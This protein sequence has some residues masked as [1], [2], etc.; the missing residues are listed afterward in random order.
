M[1]LLYQ[2]GDIP[3]YGS[4][5]ASDGDVSLG[6]DRSWEIKDTPFTGTG[7]TYNHLPIGRRI[8][9]KSDVK[10][11]GTLVSTSHQGFLHTLSRL[12]ALGGLRDVPMIVLET[13]HPSPGQSV[14]WLVAYGTVTDIDDS[15]EYGEDVNGFYQKQLSLTMKVDP[16]WRPMIR[17]YW[18]YRP[19]YSQIPALFADEGAQAGTDT[20]F[21]QPMRMS[22]VNNKNF[23]QKWGDTYSALA[24]EAW[25]IMYSDGGGYGHDYIPFGSYYLN[26]EESLW[27]APPQAIYAA[28]NLLPQGYLTI[29]TTNALTSYV[30]ELDLESLDSQLQNR[31]HT[32]LYVSD[33]LY[34]GATDPFCSFIKRDGEVLTNFVPQW[35]YTGLYPGELA[36]GYNKV[37]VYGTNTTGKFAANILYGTY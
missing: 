5:V 13:Q 17:Y 33:E 4:I 24:P 1:K 35:V 12:K 32:G 26:S 16:V 2:I 8:P 9:E 3:L 28:T 36:S 31:G 22:L 25:A 11:E 27:A 23:F 20:I 10:V 29:E 34:F 19:I 7:S 30:A 15:S 18:E 14:R 21:A 37:R 6:E